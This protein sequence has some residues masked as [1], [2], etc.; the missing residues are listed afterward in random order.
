MCRKVLSFKKVCHKFGY[1]ERMEEGRKTEYGFECEGI[2][3]EIGQGFCLS[4]KLSIYYFLLF[5]VST[6]RYCASANMET[7]L[8]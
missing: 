6:V 7:I 3:E 5:I 8:K 1:M 2:K 4:V